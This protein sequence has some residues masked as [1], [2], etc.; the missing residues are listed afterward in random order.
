[1]ALEVRNIPSLIPSLPPEPSTALITLSGISD[2]ISSLKKEISGLAKEV[3]KLGRDVPTR[4]RF[5][6]LN[7]E[8]IVRIAEVKASGIRD[9]L[10]AM[11]REISGLSSEASKLRDEA[12]DIKEAL[13]AEEV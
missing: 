1:M 6:R 12:S 9:S 5:N 2:E 10:S 13:Q 11:R 3:S 7:G 4:S 8:G